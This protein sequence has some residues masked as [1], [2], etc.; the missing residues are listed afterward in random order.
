VDELSLKQIVERLQ[1]DL[2]RSDLPSLVP[3]ITQ[4]A[5][6]AHLLNT[7]AYA[8]L[9]ELHLDGMGHSK[10]VGGR[11]SSSAQPE[12]PLPWDPFQ[13]FFQ[14]RASLS[15]E[16]IQGTPVR[17]LEHIL[18]TVRAEIERSKAS[19]SPLGKLITTE[20]EVVGILTRIRN[21]VAVFANEAERAMRAVPGPPPVPVAS[22]GIFVG[23]GRS[24][25]WLEFK[26][27]LEERLGLPVLEFNRESAAGVATPE[28]LDELLSHAH[29][30][31][32]VLTAEDRHDDG[33]KHARE[34]VIHEAG[35]FQGRLGFRRAIVL[36]EEG[37]EEFSNIHGLGQIRFRADNTAGV[38]EEIRKVL[39]RE[40]I[41]A[42]EAG[43]L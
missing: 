24:P 10:V 12:V 5:R 26:R 7:P 31:F 1:R 27:F 11:L 34:N 22:M 14:D 25:I 9:F 2:A 16:K 28:R 38:Y 41:L 8:L 6:L 29:F 13:A 18:D 42:R 23:H 3:V 21:R 33:S 15:D 39:E 19:G 32:L 4:A 36:L 37:C 20:H 40:R 35:L 30:A 43:A 17:Q